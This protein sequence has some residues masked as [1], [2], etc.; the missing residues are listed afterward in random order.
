MKK[1]AYLVIAILGLVIAS[2]APKEEL[3]DCSSTTGSYICFNG[4][5]R[6]ATYARWNFDTVQTFNAFDIQGSYPAVPGT[7]GPWT[8][9]NLTL[10]NS[11]G[12]MAMETGIYIYYDFLTNA[13]DRRF[14][15]W[16]KRY[17]DDAQ[18]PTVK[19]FVI[20][21]YG[22]AILNITNIDGSGKLS[23]QFDANVWNM[24]DTQETAVVKYRFENIELQ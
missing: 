7:T 24:A 1:S 12:S 3:V 20:N 10:V 16:M 2:C 19:N 11:T 13:G 9:V 18:D 21:P 6:T 15:F 4:E 14:T 23:G 22:T 17:E 5:G 8:T